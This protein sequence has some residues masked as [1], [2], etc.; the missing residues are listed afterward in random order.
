[1]IECLCHMCGWCPWHKKASDSLKLTIDCYKPCM[2][3]E[4]QTVKPTLQL[5][6]MKHFD[7]IW[8]NI[9]S[10]DITLDIHTNYN[11]MGGI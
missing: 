10:V 1:M 3:A 6:H 5:H 4:S 7:A 11:R 8:P 2:R 9:R